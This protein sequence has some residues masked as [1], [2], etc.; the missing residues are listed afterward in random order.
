MREEVAKTF[1]MVGS[2]IMKKNVTCLIVVLSIVL[3]F[4]A[5]ANASLIE[6]ANAGD[7][8]A[9]SKLV[10]EGA[11]L[12]ERD[13]DGD[14]AL[15]RAAFR[16]NKQIVELL[17][18]KGASVEARSNSG[19]TPF[20]RSAAKDHKDVAELLLAKGADVNARGNNG[21][22]ALHVAALNG[23]KDMADFL[24]RKGADPTIRLNDS[25]TVA[26]WA[27]DATPRMIAEYKGYTDIAV[28][29]KKAEQEGPRRIETAN[30]DPRAQAI[31]EKAAQE[32]RSAHVKPVLPE[33]ARKFMVQAEGAIRDNQF[34]EAAN[35]YAKALEIAPWS[36]EAHYN[37]AIVLGENR[38]YLGAIREM[39]RYLAL[40]PDAPDAR[41]QQDKI[42]EWQR[43]TGLSE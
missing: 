28:I 36:P 41:M 5:N 38:Y 12:N 7:I 30:E 3:L 27:R 20:I 18:A 16:G 13:G 11:N 29:L 14:T 9:V 24:L 21:G 43:K 35:F 26:A 15:H 25:R 22:T 8:E 6:A 23:L 10:Q 39:K 34:E 4:C 42:Y 31:F 2:C 40:V 19:D 33:E 17:L 32:Y 37:R 1:E